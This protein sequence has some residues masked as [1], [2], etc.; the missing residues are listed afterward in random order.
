MAH[1]VTTVII[2]SKDPELR[3]VNLAKINVW[4]RERDV[5]YIFGQEVPKDTSAGDRYSPG[6]L[7]WGAFT[8]FD[9]SGFID[10]FRSLE[11]KG[12]VLLI[13]TATGWDVIN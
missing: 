9:S 13:E 6:C 2:A 7:Y 11:W 8:S 4:L 1:D 10:F 12:A 3:D 5:Y